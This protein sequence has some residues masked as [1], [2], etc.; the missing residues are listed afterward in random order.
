MQKNIIET[1]LMNY[2]EPDIR[3][4]MNDKYNTMTSETPKGLISIIIPAYN[5]AKY[6]ETTLSNLF[7]QTYQN[8]EIIIAYDEKST[9]NTLELLLRINGTHPLTIDIGKDTSS[10]CAR[11]RGFRLAKGEFVIFVDADDEIHPQYL[12]TM[13]T[14][15]K[16]H[17]ELNVVCCDYVKVFENTIQDGWKKANASP[18]SYTI[19]SREDALYKLLWMEI[20]NTPWVFMTKRQYMIDNS[21]SFPDYS[22]G[23]DVVYAHKL[24]ANCDK[25]GRSDKKLYIFILHPTSITHQVTLDSRWSKYER[26]RCDVAAYFKESDPV[27]SDD[28]MRMM[29]RNFVYTGVLV[30][31]FPEF[32]KE[33]NAMGFTRLSMLHRHDKL[34]YKL[35]VIC[36]AV[37]K[38]L[39]YHLARYVAGRMENLTPMG[40]KLE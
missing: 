11:N 32:I 9:D 10:G 36:Y 27:Y 23:D 19:L 33:V 25:I 5:S 28:Y 20:V 38:R 35:S 29:V 26:S 8:F 40:Q 18:D 15:F 22:T 4:I 2:N 39:F 3:C 24:I 31:E 30:Y 21:I 34:P 14:I 7:A 6:I 1:V 17:P 16:E 13:I 37:S 12:E